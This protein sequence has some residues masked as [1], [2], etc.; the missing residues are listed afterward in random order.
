MVAQNPD[1]GSFGILV[2]AIATKMSI[3]SGMEASRVMSPINSNV[4]KQSRQH[5]QKEP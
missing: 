2:V 5:R 3:S 4:R 1:F